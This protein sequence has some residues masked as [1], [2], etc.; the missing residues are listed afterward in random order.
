MRDR[1][2]NFDL[3]RILAMLGVV[4]AHFYGSELNIYD[5]F[6]I[7]EANCGGLLWA[8]MEGL[9]LLA[10]PCVDCFVLISGYFMITSTH[11]RWKGLWKVWS[12]TWYYSVLIF[13]VLCLSG[14]IQ[15]TGKGLVEAITPA[16]SNE[17]WFITSYLLLVLAAPFLS[18]VASNIS[19]R[20][21]QVLLAVGFVICFEYPFGRYMASGHQLLLFFLLYF[22]GGYV[23][24]YVDRI[25]MRKVVAV[26]AGLFVVMLGYCLAKNVY[27][28]NKGLVIYSMSNN[29]LELPFSVC[30]F[31]IVKQIHID[32]LAGKIITAIAP[33]SLSVYLI[34]Y[35]L[36][37]VLWKGVGD[38][39]A[40]EVGWL[41]PLQI[42][43]I[44][45]AIFLLCIII[46]I[47]RKLLA[48][49]VFARITALMSSI[50]KHANRQ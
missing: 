40:P 33:L 41:L 50:M 8:A 35:G 29:G 42:V 13:A 4:I 24:L 2:A 19:K 9:L 22:I 6:A 34:H 17:Y 16:S 5:D 1:Q 27:L 23:R 38:L 28:G 43:L 32:G 45:S 48:P 44:S 37:P 20:Q 18:V 12:E 46:D 30:I 11:F 3:L 21:Y 31:L 26:A 14:G 47:P 36:S 25:S 49:H 39:F 7:D 10:V 15:F